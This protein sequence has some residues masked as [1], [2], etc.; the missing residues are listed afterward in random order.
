MHAGLLTTPSVFSVPTAPA[1][2]EE[3]AGRGSPG[4]MDRR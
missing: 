2:A 3:A 1:M 4:G